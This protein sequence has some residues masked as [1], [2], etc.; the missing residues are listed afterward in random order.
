MQDC[1]SGCCSE[2]EIQSP[3]DFE[4]TSVRAQVGGL[5]FR[6]LGFRVSVAAHVTKT[7]GY[8]PLIV[9]LIVR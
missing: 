2:R 7:V 5:G 9:P 4:L 1:Q 3:R 6:G 8:N